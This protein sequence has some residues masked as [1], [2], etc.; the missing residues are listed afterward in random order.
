M[1]W[2]TQLCLIMQAQWCS[3]LLFQLSRLVLHKAAVEGV[4]SWGGAATPALLVRIL[5]IIAVNVCSSSHQIAVGEA[6]ILGSK[7][8]PNYLL[9]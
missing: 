8:H 2:T 5:L 3:N 4:V 7:A 9:S 1:V 6:G